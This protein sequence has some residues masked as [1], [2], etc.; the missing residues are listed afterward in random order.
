MTRGKQ[1]RKKSVMKLKEG[2]LPEVP[3]MKRIK[4]GGGFR[5]GKST[6]GGGA[7]VREREG[8]EQSVRRVQVESTRWQLLAGAVDLHL[9]GG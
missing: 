4:V 6:A 9:I 7:A 8:K 2:C 3:V 5:E 1:K